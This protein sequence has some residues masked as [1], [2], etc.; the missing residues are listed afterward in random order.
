MSE[1]RSQEELKE[2]ERILRQFLSDLEEQIKHDPHSKGKKFDFRNNLVSIPSS[3]QQQDPKTGA[4][5]HIITTTQVPL[6]Y[7]LVNV[8]ESEEQPMK[9][10]NFNEAPEKKKQKKEKEPKKKK[11]KKGEAKEKTHET[12]PGKLE[13]TEPAEPIVVG[14]QNVCRKDC[15]V[16]LESKLKVLVQKTESEIEIEKNI[17]SIL[18]KYKI[19]RIYYDL[20]KIEQKNKRR[21][22]LSKREELCKMDCNNIDANERKTGGS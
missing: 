6:F 17:Q 3:V 10:P 8:E 11:P 15:N 2:S 16:D 18:E 22:M 7:Q 4:Y 20:K 21:D 19:S 13:I 14:N 1:Q 12:I 9:I 5:I